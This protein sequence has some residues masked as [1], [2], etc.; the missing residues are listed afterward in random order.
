MEPNRPIENPCDTIYY[1]LTRLVDNLCKT[2]NV[3]NSKFSGVSVPTLKKVDMGIQSY[4]TELSKLKNLALTLNIVP[5]EIDSKS[6]NSMT[7]IIECIQ[8]LIVKITEDIKLKVCKLIEVDNFGIGDFAYT[9]ESPLAV[10]TPNEMAFANIAIYLNSLKNI[11]NRDDYNSLIDKFIRK[12]ASQNLTILVDNTKQM[13]NDC[14]FGFMYTSILNSL[15]IITPWIKSRYGT[16][17]RCLNAIF[18]QTFDL[19][20]T[21]KS[22]L[23][24]IYSDACNVCSVQ[25]Y[26][27]VPAVIVEK[28]MRYSDLNDKLANEF[29]K[30][31][32]KISQLELVIELVNNY[33]DTHV[34]TTFIHHLCVALIGQQAPQIFSNEFALFLKELYKSFMNNSSDIIINNKIDGRLFSDISNEFINNIAHVS[35]HDNYK[36]HIEVVNGLIG[37]Q[38]NIYINFCH[39]QN[40]YQAI[41]VVFGLYNYYLNSMVTQ[42][43]VRQTELI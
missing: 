33:N 4:I 17:T 24:S 13:I 15:Y 31:A 34:L 30:F 8:Q 42:K 35:L 21:L 28:T 20:P 14:G 16:L 23:E 7:I 29:I 12:H 41:F 1:S 6:Q 32:K 3:L 26:G 18:S 11:I 38:N 2:D 22:M 43:T 37:R 19:N 39:R 5:F 36:R 25:G 10:Y 27:I 9:R 40:P